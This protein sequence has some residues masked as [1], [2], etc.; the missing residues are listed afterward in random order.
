MGF[1]LDNDLAIDM[2]FEGVTEGMTVTHTYT[3]EDE[4]VEI[5][6]E[7]YAFAAKAGA[8]QVYTLSIDKEYFDEMDAGVYTFTV[9]TFAGSLQ[10]TVDPKPSEAQWMLRS[11]RGT[12][13]SKNDGRHP[14]RSGPRQ[15]GR[16]QPKRGIISWSE[17]LSLDKPITLPFRY[18]MGNSTWV[19][20]GLMS[21][22]ATDPDFWNENS[23]FVELKAIMQPSKDSGQWQSLGGNYSGGNN[24]DVKDVVKTR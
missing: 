2:K 1:P 15:F 6:A 4:A 19:C 14:L 21:S 20:I 8:E 23:N 7:S 3:N 10:F 22:P 13:E 9:T 12:I 11:E 17:G 18:P 5:P 16:S 24:T